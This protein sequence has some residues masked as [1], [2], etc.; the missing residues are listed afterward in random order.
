MTTL[1][2]V[3][4]NVRGIGSREKR[5]KIFHHLNDL[6]ADTSKTAAPI[7]TSPQFPHTYLAC[8]N[9]KQRGVAIM[10]NKKHIFIHTNTIADPEGR[11]IIIHIS[12]QNTV[13]C[14]ANI[15]GPNI[16]DPSFF[17][18]FFTLLSAHS[19]KTLVTGGDFNLVCSPEIDRL[20]TAGNRWKWQSTGILKQYMTE[21]GL[22]DTWRSCHTTLQEYTFFSPVHHSYSC[23]D[24]FLV[25]NSIMMDVRDT[26]T[27]P[28]TI[29]DYAPVS[30][31]RKK[32]CDTTK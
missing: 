2:I 5:I 7:F 18:N 24:F 16:D 8:H 32:R 15:Y 11:F 13:L 28:I 21:F 4:W 19:G 3:S 9:S 17:H 1:K 25:S 6:Q 14:I 31:S 30:I 22:C 27:H 20:S 26:H 23:L 29:S 12:L 10:I